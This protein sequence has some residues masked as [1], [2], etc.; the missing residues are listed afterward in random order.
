MWSFFKRLLWEWRVVTIATPGV[1]GFVILV[2]FSGLLQ[3]AEWSAYDQFMQWRPTEAKDERIVIVGLDEADYD[4]IGTGKIPDIVFAELL[5]KI[6]AQNPRAIGLDYYRNLAIEPGSQELDAVL[7]SIPNLIGIRKVGGTPVSS[8]PAL[9]ELG[10]VGANDVVPDGDNKVRRG[11]LNLATPEGTEILSFGLFISLMYLDQQGIRLDVLPNGQDWTLGQATFYRF[12]S[13]DGGYIHA[14]AQGSQLLINYRGPSNHF[15]RVSLRQI[16]EDELPQDWGHDRIVLIGSFSEAEKDYFFTPYSASLLQEAEAMYGVEIHANIISQILNAALEGRP[17]IKSWPEPVEWVWILAWSG[18]GAILAWKF[19]KAGKDLKSQMPAGIFSL[20]LS[21]GALLA[22]TFVLFCKGWWLPVVPPFVAF[23][24]SSSVVTAYI[25]Q[26]AGNIRKTFGRYLSDEIVETLLESPEGLKMGGERRTIT[27]L[28][29]DLRGFTALSERLP[30][31]E[32]IKILNFYLGYMADVITSYRGTI[33]EFM[34]DGIL[35]LFGAPT[36]SRNDP[37]RA[38]ACA[39]AM[40]LAMDEVNGQ[41][42]EWGYPSLEMGIGINTGE[43]VVGNIGS[44]KRTKYGVVGSQVNL[45]YRIESYTTGGQ[46]LISE[47][48]RKAIEA[49]DKVDLRI[50]NQKEVKPKGVKK[51]ITI[52]E[53]GGI[54]EPYNLYIEKEE[55]TFITL[56]EIVSIQYAILS[57]KHVSDKVF[58]AKVCQLSRK[59]ALV[60]VEDV[61]NTPVVEALTNIKLNLLDSKQWNGSGNS[62]NSSSGNRNSGKSNSDNNSSG[63]NNSD[64]KGKTEISEDIYAKVLETPSGVGS[65]Y[66]YFTSV[67]P[68]IAKYLETLYQTAQASSV[69][70]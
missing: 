63:K 49:A 61:E 8:A 19:R 23:V 31:E 68:T 32:V 9:M 17:L 38:L 21:L 6:D 50:D 28:T 12:Q 66:I 13:N 25:A 34:G 24:G 56:S 48:T 70:A 5:E 59:Q 47:M 4:Y 46:I 53:I 64:N 65:F 51:P 54:G 67:P 58:L 2:R 55:E 22:I 7:R 45:T 14:D 42:N 41:M 26:S 10:K 37:Q 57:G 11:L 1:A 29:S 60:K 62:S 35:V 40:Q 69:S 15:E 3:G 16:L 39:V 20:I 18:G 30:P 43:V 27:I 52:Y 44:I 36:L 33:D